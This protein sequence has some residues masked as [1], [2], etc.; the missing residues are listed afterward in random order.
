M[1]RIGLA[2]Y[3]AGALIMPYGRFLAAA[4]GGATT[5]NCWVTNSASA[6]RRSVTG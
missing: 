4:E 5:L 3:F 1:A 6:L 2:N